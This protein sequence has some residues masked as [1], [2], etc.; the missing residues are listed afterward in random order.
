MEQLVQNLQREAKKMFESDDFAHQ[1]Q[2]M[3]EQLQ[4]KQQEMMEGLMEEANRN[5]FALRMTPSGIV[6]LPTKDGKPMQEADY[7]A[8]AR[9]RRKNSWKKNAARSKRQ[10]EDT[11]REGKKLEREIAE[12]LETVGNRSGG[13]FGAQS[14]DRPQR[15]IS[16]LSQECLPISTAC[17][18]IF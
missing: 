6:L 1:R 8:L 4:K 5:G 15:K 10:V 13:L 16:G 7:L 2:A 14:A 3:I 18:I 11:L 9:A 12:K 17:A